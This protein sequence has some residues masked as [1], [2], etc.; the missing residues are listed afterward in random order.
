MIRW[1]T[2]DTL[3]SVA[4]GAAFVAFFS[5]EGSTLM[6]KLGL[7]NGGRA[8]A[9]SS[10]PEEVAHQEALAFERRFPMIDVIGYGHGK[11]LEKRMTFV[12]FGVVDTEAVQAREGEIALALMQMAGRL[13]EETSEMLLVVHFSLTEGVMT[14]EFYCPK[15]EYA[16]YDDMISGGCEAAVYAPSERSPLPDSMALW[17]G[18]GR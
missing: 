8:T 9:A 10:S 5:F 4:V 17:Q 6:E 14:G 13:A 1:S 15:A 3:K 18:V 11:G 2:E 16:V 12:V 7:G